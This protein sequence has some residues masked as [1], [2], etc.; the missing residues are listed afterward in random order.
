LDGAYAGGGDSTICP[1][2]VHS[3]GMRP[4]VR[5]PPRTYFKDISSH[6]ESYRTPALPPPHNYLNLSRQSQLPR[7]FSSADLTT[8]PASM[9]AQVRT[10][11]LIADHGK[12]PESG[13][14]LRM[15]CER[16]ELPPVIRAGRRG[17]NVSSGQHGDGSGNLPASF[18]QVVWVVAGHTGASTSDP[19]PYN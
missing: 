12:G 7:W 8:C 16:L 10:G 1:R 14:R 6:L 13:R 19:S 3:R 17:T 2:S 11:C 9:F 15:S 18:L 5:E 4:L